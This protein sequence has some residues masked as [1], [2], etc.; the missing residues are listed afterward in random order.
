WANGSTATLY[1]AD[2]PNRLRGPQ[3]HWAICDEFA[4]WRYPEALD[5]LMFGLRLGQD[6]RVVIA[7]TP[8]PTK[9]VKA[10]LQQPGLV[11]T[12]GTT[13]ENLDNLAPAFR[14]QII[15]RYEGTRLGRQEL[16][17]ELL[18]DVEGALWART[19]IDADRVRHAP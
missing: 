5:M 13:Y 3:H 16:N 15:S 14:E 18:E 12:T 6:P 17:A 2:E 19:L 1:S 9:E 8:R 4:V 11:K 10:L 7:T